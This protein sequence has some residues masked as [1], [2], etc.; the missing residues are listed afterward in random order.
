MVTLDYIINMT[1]FPFLIIIEKKWNTIQKKNLKKSH[2][3]NCCLKRTW[4]SEFLLPNDKSGYAGVIFNFD[5]NDSLSFFNVDK[6]FYS[7]TCNFGFKLDDIRDD[8]TSWGNIFISISSSVETFRGFL[9]FKNN[10]EFF[11]WNNLKFLLICW[12]C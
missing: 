10:L 1:S 3:T 8:W 2:Y 9:K 5:T 7:S 11:L 6:L 12:L 4:F